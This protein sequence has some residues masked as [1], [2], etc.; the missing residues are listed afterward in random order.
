MANE[1]FDIAIVGGGVWGVYS[2]WKLQ[3]QYPDKKIGVFEGSDHIGGRL[4]SVRP[5]NID[6]MVAELGGMRVLEN[7]QLR[8]MGLIHE[9]NTHLPQDQQITLFP[10]PVDQPQNIAFLR[11]E[12]LRL[13]DFAKP[14]VV[15]YNLP[16][17]EQG[18]GPGQIIVEAIERI[19][20]GVTNPA[21]NEEQRRDLCRKAVF[22]GTPLYQ[23]GFWNAL[24]QVISSE[25]YQYAEDAGGYD[26]T[27]VNWNAADAIPWYLSD[28]GIQPVYSGFKNGFQQVPITLAELFEKGGGEIRLQ[29]QLRGFEWMGSS[30]FDLIF[31]DG[32][33]ISAGALIL[34]M[35]RRSLDL[36]M[37]HASKLQDIK[38]L[39]SAVTPRPLFK[40][41]T[42]YE[43]PWWRVGSPAV[44]AGRSVT[45]IPVRQTYYWPLNT[46]DPVKQGRSMLLASYD[47]GNNV[48]YWDGMRPQRKLTWQKATSR[49][50]I[51]DPYI[52]PDDKAIREPNLK[53]DRLNQHWA[54][55]KASR[56][57]VEEVTRQLGQMHEADAPLPQ[58]AAFRDW[59]EDP[60]GG[61]WNSWNIGVKSWEVKDEIVNPIPGVPLYICG[62]AYSD[63]Q[64]WVEGALQT[65]D[66]MLTRFVLRPEK[67]SRMQATK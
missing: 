62:E 29:W 34:A 7:N 55:Y 5:P 65:A 22:K 1:H 43:Q 56:R 37:P 48:G 47:D 11:G 60:F 50:E 59:G 67:T 13:A 35:P 9:L 26:S 32:D 38:T 64:G 44:E 3:Q 54:Q 8:V 28:F 57:M 21:L 45:D 58:S 61:G 40:L 46:G 16:K 49:P 15:P 14:G 39:I 24:Y 20:P 17:D 6:N 53:N 41:F 12:H 25:A 4:L 18:K 10:F 33:I 63:A 42:S 51:P 27:L 52:G 30:R 19:V 23:W 66:L 31:N 36:L 2:A